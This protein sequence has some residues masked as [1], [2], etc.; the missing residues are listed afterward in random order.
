MPQRAPHRGADRRRRQ[1]RRLAPVASASAACSA[2]AR[3]SSRSR[4]APTC[5]RRCASRSSTRPSPWRKAANYRSLGTFEFLVEE[6]RR[7]LR[8]HR[9]QSA[10]A[11][12]AHGHRG[13]DGRRPGAGAAA[14]RRR[15]DAGRTGLPRRR[16]GAARLC[17]PGARQHGDHDG[18]RLGQAG[19]RHAHRVRAAVRARR[20]RRYLRLCRLPHQS[21]LRLAARQGDR[22][23]RAGDFADGARA[24]PSGRSASSGSRARHQH[25]LP[26]RLL[27][28]PDVARRQGPH[29]LRRRALRRADRRG[30]EAAARALLPG[31]GA[32][33]PAARG[34]P[35][36]RSMPSIRWRCWRSARRRP[37]ADRPRTSRAGRAGGHACAVRAPMQ[38]TIVSIVG[39]GGRRR[40]APASRCWSWKP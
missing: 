38:G 17:H 4:P 8:L 6:R 36:P 14:A 3:R 34:R 19:R 1:G 28:H 25:R 35:A 39:E 7:A 15:R 23:R 9:G 37:Q 13:G 26:A 29:A 21:Q 12:R 5:R 27:A 32:G 16:A 24:G 10:P 30:G 11:G 18:G 33:A 20:A 2:A 40:R 22:A 31:R